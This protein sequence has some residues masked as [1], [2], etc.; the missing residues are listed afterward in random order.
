MKC[1]L[2]LLPS[3]ELEVFFNPTFAL[4]QLGVKRLHYTKKFQLAAYKYLSRF[5]FNL[6][7]TAS[8][9]IFKQQD[10]R[11]SKRTWYRSKCKKDLQN[12]MNIQGCPKVGQVIGSCLARNSTVRVRKREP[13]PITSSGIATRLGRTP[14]IFFN[15]GLMMQIKADR[16]QQAMLSSS[17]SCLNSKRF[18]SPISLFFTWST[19]LSHVSKVLVKKK[20]E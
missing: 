5:T 3:V 18:V 1:N 13:L 8:S 12:H 15:V 9:D 7:L 4:W 17:F 11:N 16:Q 10:S 20:I 6:S 19:P 2:E 14:C